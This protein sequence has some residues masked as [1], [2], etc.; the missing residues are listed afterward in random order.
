MLTAL[1]LRVMDVNPAVA[2]SRSV[3]AWK[4]AESPGLDPDSPIWDEITALTIPLTAQQVT[5][6]VGGGTVPS[7]RV[8]AAHHD[9]T[10]YVNIE[11]TD[12]TLDD[13]SGAPEEFADAVAIQ[14]PAEHGA[15][16]P[17]VC[18]GQAD[19]AVNIWQWRAD[20]QHG[21]D[22]LGKGSDF[23]DLY[24]NTDEL[25][26]PAQRAG[27]ALATPGA[28]VVQNLVASGFGTLEPAS[29]GVVAGQGRH[30][31]S[32][33]R[34]VFARPFPAQDDFQPTFKAGVEFDV[35][36]A[37]WDGR[38]A[39]RDG[40]KS[41][42]SFVR[43]KV[44]DKTAAQPTTGGSEGGSSTGWLIVLTAAILGFGAYAVFIF[45]IPKPAPSKED[46]V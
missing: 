1:V 4:V 3:T 20:R 12:T 45:L 32:Q 10:L 15:A 46:A 24:P 23:V 17:A 41:V 25:F 37:V 11:W 28:E 38:R 22:Q 42:S 16:V 8:S 9:Q 19:G 18:M 34:A 33:W 43:L 36:F 14:I 27:N 6:P 5:A 13:G 39:D 26:Y 21:L 35:A 2:Q 31:D 40:Q 30:L 29:L 44:S 7:V